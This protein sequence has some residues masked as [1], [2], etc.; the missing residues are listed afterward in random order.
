MNGWHLAGGFFCLIAGVGVFTNMEIEAFRV[1]IV[2]ALISY[3]LGYH[4]NTQERIDRLEKKIDQLTEMLK[5]S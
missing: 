1:L 2:I 4:F 5:K 3:C